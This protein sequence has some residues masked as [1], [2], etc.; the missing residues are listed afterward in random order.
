MSSTVL[1][2][3]RSLITAKPN[4]GSGSG[5]N[6]L[7]PWLL[8]N[9]GR[10]SRFRAPRVVVE[11]SSP[12]VAKPFHVGHLRSTLLGAFISRLLPLAKTEVIRLNWLGDWGTQFGLLGTNWNPAQGPMSLSGLFN[13][14]VEAN[15]KAEADPEFYESAKRWFNR[16]ESGDAEAKKFWLECCE[17]SR[18]EFEKIDC[19]N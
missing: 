1:G 13:T 10:V 2:R 15:K 3:F 17:I 19:R 6:E 4:Q 14:Y 18:R 11:F 8:M 16:L 5:S 7:L 12:N 9:S